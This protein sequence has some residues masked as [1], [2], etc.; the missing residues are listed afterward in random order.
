[1]KLVTFISAGAFILASAFIIKKNHPVQSRSIF[2]TKWML[3]QIATDSVQPQMNGRAFI[4][5]DREKQSAGGNGSCNSFGSTAK[6]EGN[7][8]QVSRIFSTKMYCEGVQ[9]T[10]D[11]FFRLLEKSNRF[12]ISDQQLTLYQDDQLLLVFKAAS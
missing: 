4:R 11:Q 8:L 3:T 10:E 6:V 2:E 12:T 7:T 5:F 9:S 1:M